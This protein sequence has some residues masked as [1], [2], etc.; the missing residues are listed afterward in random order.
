MIDLHSYQFF[1]AAW[2][3]VF[4]FMLVIFRAEIVLHLF[5]AAICMAQIN[6]WFQELDFQ[7]IPFFVLCAFFLL[8]RMKFWR[9]R[10]PQT[11]SLNFGTATSLVFILLMSQIEPGIPEQWQIIVFCL[12]IAVGTVQWW[13]FLGE[14]TNIS[15]GAK[16]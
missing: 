2:G 7:I 12:G 14:G 10:F 9:I 13:L 8:P 15:K 16:K 5:L 1:W 3:T 6:I 11:L 4:F